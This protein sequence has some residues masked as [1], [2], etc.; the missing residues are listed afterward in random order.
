MSQWGMI[1]QLFYLEWL[2]QFRN[3]QE[4]FNAAIFFLIVLCIF[5]LIMTPDRLILTQ[6]APGVIWIAVLFS[7]FLALQHL[8]RDEYENGYI[9][10]M[11]FGPVSLTQQ[12]L[13]KIIVHWCFS[14]LPLTCLA[15][16]L[17]V[18]FY[19]KASA[20]IAVFISTLLGTFILSLLGMAIAAL[21]I[22]LKQQS[23]L[24]PIL[25]I[26]FALP[27]LIFG[28]S[29]IMFA[30]ES[31]MPLGQYAFLLAISLVAI[32]FSP[33]ATSAILKLKVFE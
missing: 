32:L 23:I 12:V 9:D 2:N 11:F 1:R 25:L 27:M 16:A 19:L 4:Y 20:I 7:Q 13:C 31:I 29:A 18:L 3:K 8:F 17:S 14:G 28:S 30:N 33:L 10:K 15:A 24:I 5:P 6:I 21:T 22:G 26:P